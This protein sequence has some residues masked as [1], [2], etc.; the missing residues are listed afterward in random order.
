MN[1]KKPILL[2]EDDRVD[3]LTVKRAMGSIGFINELIIKTTGEEA[4]TY[5]Q[6]PLNKKPSI[7]LLDLNMP[8]MNGL[9]FLQLIKSDEELKIIPVIILTTSRNEN[10]RL[11]AFKWSVAGYMIKPIDYS[12]FVDLISMI[13]KYW[14][15]SEFPW[16]E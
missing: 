15:I 13:D 1:S 9:E 7:I 16:D 8:R 2:I 12:M 6:N 11:E 3:A 4:L 5:L 10:D 14:G